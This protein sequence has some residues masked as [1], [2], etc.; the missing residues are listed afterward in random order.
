VVAGEIIMNLAMKTG[1]EIIP[2]DSEHSAILQC[3]AG[4][5]H[6]SIKRVILTASGGPF[7]TRPKETFDSITV[8]DALKHPN[9]T[10]GRKITIDSAT[11]MNKGL[12]LIEAR[13][14]FNVGA[15]KLEVLVHTQSII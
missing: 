10:M 7:R 3:L 6:E 14:L 8:Q 9:W 13:W 12:E 5:S 15:D 1:A 2:I 4:E 11:L